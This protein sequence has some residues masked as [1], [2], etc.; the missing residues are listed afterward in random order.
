MLS[1]V[2]RPRDVVENLAPGCRP[3]RW[4]QVSSCSGL[5]EREVGPWQLQEAASSPGWFAGPAGVIRIL[6]GG[7]GSSW[8]R[9]RGPSRVGSLWAAGPHWP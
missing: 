7:Q 3:R 5:R 6:E 4:S 2:H 8:Q 9:P 1:G